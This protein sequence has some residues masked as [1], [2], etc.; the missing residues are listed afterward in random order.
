MSDLNQQPLIATGGVDPVPSVPPEKP[1]TVY[2]I[3]VFFT[4]LWLFFLGSL[5]FTL[6]HT[7][8]PEMR[9]RFLGSPA[10]VPSA[11]SELNGLLM[12]VASWLLVKMR[13][14][15]ASLFLISTLLLLALVAM[16]WPALLPMYLR[17]HNPALLRSL[18]MGSSNL[19][20][21]IAATIYAFHLNRRG[22]LR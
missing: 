21:H 5:L 18:A 1:V 3:A 14:I 17:S 16:S 8:S 7:F 9:M 15:G 12:V 13:R 22:L 19:V 11:I 2:L 6:F 4:G 20:L 10:V